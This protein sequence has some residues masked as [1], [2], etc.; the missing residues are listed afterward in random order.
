MRRLELLIEIARENT[1][2][3]RYDANSGISQRRFAQM[4][5]NAQDFIV[6][7][8]VNAKSKMFLTQELVTV[9]ND[10]EEYSYPA[11]IYMQNIDTM[12]WSSNGT[13]DYITLERCITK[14]RYTRQTGYPF[15][16][17]T[18]NTG[19]CMTP[20]LTSGTLRVNYIKNPKRLEKRSGEVVS[21][22]GTPITSITI[23]TG[24]AS[25]D[26][27]YINKFSYISIVDKY[28]NIKADNIP[29]TA[30]SG[31]TITVA[32][33]TLGSGETI[34]AGDFVI[35]DQNSCNI[36]Q[37]SDILESVLIKHVE[38]QVRY[39]DSSKW[40]AETKQDLNESVMQ[41]IESFGK[42]TDDITQ[43]PIINTDFLAM[44]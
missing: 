10:Q 13:N 41:I 24:D 16:Y 9:V 42:N 12:E 27:D 37:M 15:G 21:T 43:V 18:R 4:F 31:G 33:Y 19:Y 32:S 11:D 23:D 20:P 26:P 8:A 39:G 22:T 1:Q 35:C 44:W 25:H 7:S 5:Q 40:S 14:D 36:P 34:S 29:I 3:S 38:Y 28:G 30:A 6:R 17:W 2:N